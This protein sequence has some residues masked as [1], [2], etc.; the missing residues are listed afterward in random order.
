MLAAFDGR[1]IAEGIDGKM[2]SHAIG[3]H[4]KTA[5]GTAPVNAVVRETIVERQVHFQSSE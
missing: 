2:Y 4:G 1:M 5:A 3:D